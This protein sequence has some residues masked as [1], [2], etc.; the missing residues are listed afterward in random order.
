MGLEQYSNA[1]FVAEFEINLERLQLSATPTESLCAYVLGGQSGAGKARLG[2]RLNKNAIVIDGDKFRNQHPNS[3]E[4]DALYGVD[5]VK[6]KSKFA[7]EMT[8]ALINELSKLK[9]NLVIEGTLRTAEVPLKTARELQNKGY[10]VDLD[11]KIV[12]PEISY[13]STILR[14]I[15]GRSEGDEFARATPKEHHDL[16]VKSLSANLVTLIETDAFKTVSLYNRADEEIY[17]SENDVDVNPIE[18]I[19]N[20]MFGEWSSVEVA[21]L[22][23]ICSKIKSSEYYDGLSDEDKSFLADCEAI[24]V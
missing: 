10:S 8:E 1:E 6:Y 24:I 17:N 5:S 23:E 19:D 11:V 9:Y 12:K 7:G 3:D 15:L 18:L 13:A 14:Y 21:G 4:L 20:I 16:I 2:N 22:K